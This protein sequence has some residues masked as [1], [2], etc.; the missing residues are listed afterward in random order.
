[1]TK[2]F[3]ERRHGS[4]YLI[5][6]RVPLALIVHEFR[7]GESPEAIQTHY[8]TL[9]LEQ[10]SGAITFYLG[11]KEEVEKDLVERRRIED[12]FTKRHAAPPKLKQKLER[13]REQMLSRQS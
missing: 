1:M 4:F 2:E 10:V 5:G 11:N 3:V 8:P 13:V 7:N 9:S 6:S 12:E